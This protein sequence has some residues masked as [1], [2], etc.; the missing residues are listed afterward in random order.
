MG[1]LK[2]FGVIFAILGIVIML[3]IACGPGEAPSPPPQPTPAA[4]EPSANQPP[5]ILSLTSSQ[6]E[7]Y[8]SAQA[9]VYPRRIEIR[10]D[11]SDADGDAI[12]Y[13]WSATGGSFT[14]TGPTVS[15]MAPK[16]Y[17][18]YDVTITAKD[19]KGGI[20]QATTTVSVVRNENPL[21][22]SLVASPDTVQPGET[23]TITCVASDPDGDVLD[24]D[25]K[26]SGGSVTGVGNTVTWVGPDIEGE[27]TITVTVGDGKGGQNVR[28]V[29]VSAEFAVKTVTFNPVANETGTVSDTGDKDTSRAKAGDSDT[30]VSYCAFWSFAL[31]SLRGTDIKDAKLTFTTK[32]VVGEPFKLTSG[33][34]GLNLWR[35]R[36]EPGELPDFDTPRGLYKEVASAM[37]EPPTVTDV[38][39]VVGNIAR[40]TSDRLQVEARFMRITNGNYVADYIEWASVTLTVTYAER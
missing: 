32:N 25:W 14:G 9:D 24:Y 40:G 16:Q 17:G 11:A 2:R 7:V 21:I 5:V 38:T 33:L 10:C 30:N 34:D 12:S 31:Y 19:G 22:S 13:E 4:P 6:T 1:I 8:L 28:N 18:N 27:F 26:A 29:S 15:W 23:A 39:K 35:V 3:S 37:W 36:Y 20:T